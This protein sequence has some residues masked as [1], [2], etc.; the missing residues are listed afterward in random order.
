MKSTGSFPNHVF[1]YTVLTIVFTVV[2]LLVSL[3]VWLWLLPYN[4]SDTATVTWKRGGATSVIT[5]KVVDAEGRP[6]CGAPVGIE[7]SS[8]TTSVLTDANGVAVIRPGEND[9]VAFYLND[10]KLVEWPLW[11][12]LDCSEGLE[13]T[14]LLSQ[15]VK[16][17][18]R[19][20]PHDGNSGASQC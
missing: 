7:T 4:C 9:I 5:I 15:V 13:V 11:F 8:G 10:V 20:E 14:I 12:T 6:S 16:G 2:L 3:L 19:N 17:G 1:A 18:A